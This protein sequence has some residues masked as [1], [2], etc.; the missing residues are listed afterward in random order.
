MACRE[1]ILPRDYESSKPKEWIRGDTKI[2]PVLEVATRYSQR[3][4]GVEIRIKSSSEDELDQD[5]F[6]GLNKFVREWIDK[7]RIW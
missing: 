4:Y 7:S 2:G 5:I 1:Y 3:K 6:H